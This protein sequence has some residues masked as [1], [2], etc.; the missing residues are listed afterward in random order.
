MMQLDDWI[1]RNQKELGHHPPG[2]I[3]WAMALY[4]LTE[5]LEHRFVETDNI[6]DS[7]E[8]IALH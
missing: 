1:A 7:D 6:A 8:T 3:G 5:S 2:D 4:K